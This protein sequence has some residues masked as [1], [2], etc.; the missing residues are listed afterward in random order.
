MKAI[1]ITQCLQNDFVKPIGKYD[2]IPNLL[3]IGYDESKRLMGINPVEGP[4]ARV[5]NWA[6]DQSPDEMRIRFGPV[7]PCRIAGTR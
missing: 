5:M 6:Y 3:H 7:P 1:L 4:V 2:S